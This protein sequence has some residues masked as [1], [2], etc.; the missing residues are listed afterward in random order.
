MFESRRRIRLLVAAIHVRFA[1]AQ[2]AAG[3]IIARTHGWNTETSIEHVVPVCETDAAINA[4]L[5]QLNA[6]Y[7]S[8]YD[9]GVDFLRVA[10]VSVKRN[11]ATFTNTLRHMA[12]RRPVVGVVVTSVHDQLIE[13]IKVDVPVTGTAV[14]LSRLDDVTAA[15]SS[16][17]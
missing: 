16:G 15:R 10:P 9:V 4:E 5:Q 12:K 17:R 6:V 2:F 7:I 8:L 11:A 1:V 13:Q 3:G 14:F